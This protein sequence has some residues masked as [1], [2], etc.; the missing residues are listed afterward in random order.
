[1]DFDLT[2]EQGVLDHARYLKNI[3]APPIYYAMDES[4]QFYAYGYGGM[5][6]WLAV[7]ISDERA[8]VLKVLVENQKLVVARHQNFYGTIL[9][10]LV[11]AKD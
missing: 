10:L 8:D 7:E 2:T 3:A 4:G 1:M 11:P 9:Q 6:E 5:G